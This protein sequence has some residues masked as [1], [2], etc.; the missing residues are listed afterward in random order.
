MTTDTSPDAERDRRARRLAR[1]AADALTD[2]GHL[3]GP[4]MTAGEQAAAAE[5]WLRERGHD[6]LW[7]DYDTATA[8]ARRIR[9][10]FDD[11][12]M[13]AVCH[14]RSGWTCLATATSDLGDRRVFWDIVDGSRKYATGRP[15]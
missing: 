3:T 14:P 2:T 11:A 12:F 1:I 15:A 13:I 6:P 9:H 8:V 4:S 5:A 7:Q 10:W